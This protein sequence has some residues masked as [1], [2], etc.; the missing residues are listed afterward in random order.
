MI[1]LLPYTVLF[2]IGLLNSGNTSNRIRFVSCAIMFVALSL[3]MGLRSVNY[4]GSDTIVYARDFERIIRNNYSFTEIFTYFEKDYLFYLFA[5]LFSLVSTETSLWILVCAVLYIYAVS[6]F[7]Y[8]Y[9]K[10]IFLSYMIFMSWDFY[11]YNYQLMR[12]CFALTFV[13][14]S[15]KYVLNRNLGK[16]LLCLIGAVSSQIVS[17]VSIGSYWLKKVNI[18]IL[19]SIILF[20][21]LLLTVLP[22]EQLIDIIFS[23]SWIDID[24]FEQFKTRGGSAV[25]NTFICLSFIVVTIYMIRKHKDT[26]FLHNDYKNLPLFLTMS[27]IALSLY[28][29]QFL[30]AEFYRVAQFFSYITIVMVP[31][32]LNMEKNKTIKL[33]IIIVI[34]AFCLKHFWGGL[35]SATEYYP[36]KFYWE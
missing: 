13:I 34:S 4:A 5:K 7:I 35:L 2:I 32:A 6:W 12:H 8:R 26:Y 23:F 20:F 10:N 28:S 22:R 25:T 24:R 30:I 15:L 3:I 36:Y 29:M 31:L 33:I 18:K 9:S 21:I 16:Y 11:L 19:V 27:F 1:F 17:I 14:L